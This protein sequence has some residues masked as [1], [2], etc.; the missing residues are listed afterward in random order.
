VARYSKHVTNITKTTN[1]NLREG[2]LVKRGKFRKS[3][4]QRWFVLKP[5]GIYYYKK[6]VDATPIKVLPIQ[7]IRDCAPCEE[8]I[9][10]T[11][12]I[13]SHIL[14]FFFFKVV[15]NDVGKD[16]R[17]YFLAA[18]SE[19]EMHEWIRFLKQVLQLRQEETVVS[20]QE[21]KRDSDSE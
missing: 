11:L 18:T 10:E 14:G 15:C 4:K 19:D 5:D 9:I 17:D 2:F 7:Q 1:L 12:N 21:L 20:H 3:W 6:R 8:N 16:F 13:P